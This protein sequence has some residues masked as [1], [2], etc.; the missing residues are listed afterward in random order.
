[1]KKNLAA[2]VLLV[3]LCAVPIVQVMANDVDDDGDGVDDKIE[4]AEERGLQIEVSGSDAAVKS[5][6]GN[7]TM[8][9]EFE[10]VFSTDEGIYLDLGYSSETS[11]TEYELEVEVRFLQ[12]IEFIDQNEDGVISEGEDVNNTIDLADLE[13]STPDVA[14]ITSDDGEAGYRFESHLLGES[15]VFQIIAD[16]FPTYAV[17]NDTTVNPME[18]KITII[19]DG[20][21]YVQNGSLALMVQ[22]TSEIGMEQESTDTETEIEVESDTATGYFSWSD[23]ATVDGV[24]RPV[25]SMVTETEEGSLIA[26]CYPHGRSIVH[27]PKLGV[28]L[29]PIARFPLITPEILLGT[30]IAAT[31]IAVAA[32]AFTRRRRKL[33]P[34]ETATSLA[35]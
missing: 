34:L 15:F 23:N 24:A 2:L 6:F 29:L 14:P 12:L 10:I 27:D 30:A 28:S 13:Y 22:A 3:M 32:I 20:F 25:S 31:A 26:L 21:P 9:N 7:E 1:M 16:I 5:E 8:E 33:R 11:P 35:P 17:I 18:M 19:I 4:N